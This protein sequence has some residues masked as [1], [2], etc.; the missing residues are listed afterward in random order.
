LLGN[1]FGDR[2]AA[3]RAARRLLGGLGRSQRG[4]F[5]RGRRIA[6][7][8]HSPAFLEEHFDFTRRARLRFRR[9]LRIRLALLGA[10][11]KL[12]DLVSQRIGL[13]TACLYG[14]RPGLRRL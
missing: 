1:V 14:L 5:W 11:Q 4:S 7:L 2:L 13:L 9:W 10:S 3:L 12:F 6:A 8:D